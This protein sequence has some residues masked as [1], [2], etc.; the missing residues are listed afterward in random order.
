[1]RSIGP[2]PQRTMVVADSH[3]TVVG[4][5]PEALTRPAE[6]LHG[7]AYQR[8]VALLAWTQT[9]RESLWGDRDDVSPTSLDT[10]EP[11]AVPGGVEV[12]LVGLGR[13]DP[14]QHEDK[15]NPHRGG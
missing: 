12:G 7:L 11:E 4:A 6:P 10:L 14:Q 13:A 15:A 9:S 2:H 8:A 3:T 1:M 5:C